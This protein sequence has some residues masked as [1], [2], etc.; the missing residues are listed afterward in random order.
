MAMVAHEFMTK[1]PAAPLL[2]VAL[3]LALGATTP[4]GAK[5]TAGS[6]LP[7]KLPSLKIHFQSS[8]EDQTGETLR[9]RGHDARQQL[10][11]TAKF[12]GGAVRDFTRQVAYETSPAGIVQVSKTGLVTPLSD[13]TATIVAK[14]SGGCAAKLA[15]TVEKFKTITPVNFPHQIVP[16]FT[17]AGCNGGGG[18]GKSSGHN[19]FPLSLPRLQTSEKF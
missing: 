11:I 6:G 2:G 5:E 1:C 16:I 10:L 14:D 17:K 18:Q 7:G 12:D 15:V 13:G 9:L 19:S 3:L 4:A 8:G